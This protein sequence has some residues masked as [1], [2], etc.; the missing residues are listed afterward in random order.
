[1]AKERRRS[2]IPDPRTVGL[3]D[4]VRPHH[5]RMLEELCAKA[6]VIPERAF[7]FRCAL[8]RLERQPSETSNGESED[9]A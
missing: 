1:M 4:K 2:Y 5:Q 8:T 7:T 9:H 3:A 6:A